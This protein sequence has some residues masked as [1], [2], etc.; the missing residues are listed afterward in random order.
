MARLALVWVVLVLVGCGS[1][2]GGSGAGDVREVVVDFSLSPTSPHAA[3]T[4]YDTGRIRVRPDQEWAEQL[5]ML[6]VHELE[7]A[8]GLEGH[9][10]EGSGCYRQPD[11]FTLVPGQAP[12]LG[13]LE[14]MAGLEGT[15]TVRVS[16]NEPALGPAVAYACSFWNGHVGREVFEFEYT[17]E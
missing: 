4:E 11:V 7:H 17:T 5:P 15:W 9:L 3:F 13:E 1:G 12:C 8:A 14:Q 6:L 10:P 2:G 16:V